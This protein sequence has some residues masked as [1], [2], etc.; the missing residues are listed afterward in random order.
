[1]NMFSSTEHETFSRMNREGSI[2]RNILTTPSRTRPKMANRNPTTSPRSART[3]FAFLRRILPPTFRASSTQ[4]EISNP[5]A[6]PS[7]VAQGPWLVDTTGRC[8][9]RLA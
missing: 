1:M 2:S 7:W 5:V 6:T 8:F 4:V 3:V 9:V